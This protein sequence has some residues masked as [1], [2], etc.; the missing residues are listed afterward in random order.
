[1]MSVIFFVSVCVSSSI[2]CC[3]SK[4]LRKSV[5]NWTDLI[6]F[7]ILLIGKFKC[8]VS[9]SYPSMMESRRASENVKGKKKK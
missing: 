2:F 4:I 9:V 1:M 6:W 8:K 7:K 3:V 5:R